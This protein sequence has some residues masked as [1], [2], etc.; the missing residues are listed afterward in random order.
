NEDADP[1]N[2]LHGLLV[3]HATGGLNTTMTSAGLADADEHIRAWT[4]RLVLE[5]EQDSK[6]W[7]EIVAGLAEK[8]PSPVVRRA[9]ASGL[10]RLAPEQRLT[11]L[12]TLTR[13]ES[14]AG[15]ANLP[16]MYW[17]AMEPLADVDP[18]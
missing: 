2:R 9:I 13:H 8:D 16:F 15:D 10:A 3:F 11:V 14:D 18:A 17:Y 6:G 7:L 5:D 1:R 4:V 12:R